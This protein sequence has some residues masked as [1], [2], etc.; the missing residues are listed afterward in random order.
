MH[1]PLGQRGDLSLGLADLLADLVGARLGLCL[2]QLPCLGTELFAQLMDPDFCMPLF[3][4]EIRSLGLHV[5]VVSVAQILDDLQRG[6]VLPGQ[7]DRFQSSVHPV[8]W[9]GGGLRA[10]SHQP[11]RH[12]VH[13]VRFSQG[14]DRLLRLPERDGRLPL[15]LQLLFELPVELE[16]KFLVRLLAPES[17]VQF[18]NRAGNLFGALRFGAGIKCSQ[19]AKHPV[20]VLAPPL[21][22][23]LDARTVLLQV[24]TQLLQC[25]ELTGSGPP[26]GGSG[27]GRQS[28]LFRG[29]RP[30]LLQFRQTLV[31]IADLQVLQAHC[32]QL[33]LDNRSIVHIRGWLDAGAVPEVHPLLFGVLKVC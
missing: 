1:P 32:G 14:V 30:G 24:V 16:R 27:R 5:C 3:V 22:D 29:L 18:P 13:P 4:F 12:I 19:G 9:G 6:R 7:L 33:V 15:L 2:F 26:R 11:E 17:V 25:V 23:A 21:F 31:K 10:L 20:L 28:S 8:G